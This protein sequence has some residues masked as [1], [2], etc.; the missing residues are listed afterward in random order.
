MGEQG[1]KSKTLK[2]SHAFHSPL[3]EP[4]LDD[5]LAVSQ[6]IQYSEPQLDLISNV[7]GTR[8][9]SEVANAE[10]WVRHILSPVRFY[11]GIRS[12]REESGKRTVFIEVGPNPILLGMAQRCFEDGE[13]T[14]L[15]TLRG[16]RGAK[17]ASA[18]VRPYMTLGELYVRGVEVDW[19]GFDQD[20]AR[21]KVLLPTYPFQRERYWVEAT[22]K[23][24]PIRC[25]SS[26]E[27][28]LLQE[29]VYSAAFKKGEIQF[30]AQLSSTSPTYLS[31]HQLFGS[32]ASGQIILPATAYLEMAL[33]AGA[34]LLQTSQLTVSEVVIQQA[35]LLPEHVPGGDEKPKTVQFILTPEERG[36]DWEIFSLFA[37]DTPFVRHAS[38]K[39]R[40]GEAAHVAGELATLQARCQEE[41]DVAAYYQQFREQK[42]VYGANF[43]GLC[44]LWGSPGEALG[45]VRLPSELDSAP[46]QWH[47]ALLDACFQVL[48]AALPPLSE[49][50]L[51]VGCQRLTVWARPSDEIWSYAK[52]RSVTSEEKGTL[53]AD[54][55]LFS[56]EGQLYGEIVGL[57]L[58]R[59]NRQAVLGKPRWAEWLYKV[60]WQADEKGSEMADGSKEPY[61][62]QEEHLSGDWLIL[63]ERG[64]LGESLASAWRDQGMDYLLVY[65]GQTYQRLNE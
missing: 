34:R 61:I 3:M 55:Q 43:Q 38:G 52:V 46:Y 41:L 45:Q 17:G 54:L 20:W 39:L 32:G 44:R 59:A 10:Y 24:L 18:R 35:L 60:V 49:T 9:G 64:G 30:E 4:I 7:T 8:V 50:Y 12:L 21:R 6:Q 26:N 28:P 53:T 31:H 57:Q 40:V 11:D 63:A 47:P 5:F 19:A 15:P 48:M 42:I 58:K 22:P 13:G 23:R 1:I 33:A 27:H 25:A 36:Y 2:V 14:W 56:K 37:C 51:P 16:A 65:R 29:R 62:A